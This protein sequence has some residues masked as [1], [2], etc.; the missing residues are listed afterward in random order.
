L[1]PWRRKLEEFR[2]A[3]AKRGERPT[4]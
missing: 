2:T 3:V 4:V 1:P